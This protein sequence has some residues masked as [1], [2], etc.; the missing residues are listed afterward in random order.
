MSSRGRIAQLDRDFRSGDTDPELTADFIGC[1]SILKEFCRKTPVTVILQ[2]HLQ[3]MFMTEI[4]Q[5]AHVIARNPIGN[6]TAQI[7]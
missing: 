5:A 2:P 1:P 7:P 4:A 3:A 6:Q